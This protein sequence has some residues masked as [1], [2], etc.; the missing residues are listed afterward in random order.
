LTSKDKKK[1]Y[2]VFEESMEKSQSLSPKDDLTFFFRTHP[3]SFPKRAAPSGIVD[4]C[5]FRLGNLFN[6][7]RL[8]KN[9]V[10]HNRQIFYIIFRSNI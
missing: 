4:I 1:D 3:V 9:Q 6:F 5:D 2:L 8:S 10:L 7:K